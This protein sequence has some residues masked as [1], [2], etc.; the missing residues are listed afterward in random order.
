M[1]DEIPKGTPESVVARAAEPPRV[2]DFEPTLGIEVARSF[3]GTPRHRLVAL[4]DS[5]L[6]GFQS[7]AIYNTD[8]SVPAIVAYELG[9]DFR[10]P[11]YGG[12]GGLPLN[13]ELLLRRIEQRHGTT[14]EPWELPTALLAARGFMD[15][16]EDYWERGPGAAFPSVGYLHNL[17]CFGW[18]LRDALQKTARD[19]AARIRT[20]RDDLVRQLVENNGERAALHVYPNGDERRRDLTLFDVAAEL[21]ADHDDATDTGIETLLVFLGSNNA[22]RTVTELRVAWSGDDFRDLDAKRAYTIWRPEHFD[23]EWTE[24]LARLRTV[25]ARH[26][27]LCTVPHVT[28]APIARGLGTKSGSRYFPY[29]SRPWVDERRFEASRDEHITGPE[30]RMVDAAID[31]FDETISRT[32]ADARRAGLDWYLLDTAGILDRLAARRY[33]DDLEARPAWWQPYALP[34]AL[35]ALDPVPDTRFLSADGRGGRA[36]GG[37]FSLDGVHPTTVGYGILAQEVLDVMVR[38]GVEFR[39]AN[40][41]VRT[42]AVAVDFERLL[43]RDT[44]VR[45]PPQNLDSMLSI[46]GWLDEVLDVFRVQ[47]RLGL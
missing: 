7:G 12:P 41:T 34:P 40:G 36:S 5:L 18:D 44:L 25:G 46:L 42:G 43:R 29:Y 8:I 22:L 13:I 14:L 37:L 45:T 4:G 28:I 38:A 21:G 10:Y 2:P 32:V 11:R 24:V 9:A 30:A 31:L 23:S 6:Q 47:L 35:A 17:S 15:E 1:T 3:R 26:V 16:V 39:T 27:V 33:V 20:P 19:C